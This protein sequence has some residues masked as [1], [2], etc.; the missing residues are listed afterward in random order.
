M[1]ELDI[2]SEVVVNLQKLLIDNDVFL[3]STVA[4]FESS[5][6]QRAFAD[7]RSLRAM[8]PYLIQRYEERRAANDE[9]MGDST[10][11]NRFKRIM[12]FERQFVELGGLMGSGV[13]PGRHNLPGYGDQRNFELFLEAGFS[14]Q[15]AIQIMTVNGAKILGKEN[16]GSIEV[17]KRADLVVLEGDLLSDPSVIKQVEWV[18]KN[19]N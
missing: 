15:E 18:F 16:I 10:R 3:T 6:P 17:G 19:V 12:A 14:T 5:V 13:D 1:D 11:V 4:I 9:V 8:S 2:A 7:K